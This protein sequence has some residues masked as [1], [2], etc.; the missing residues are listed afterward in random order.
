MRGVINAFA[1]SDLEM[2]KIL[3]WEMALEDKELAMK[4]ATWRLFNIAGAV[5]TMECELYEQDS[6]PESGKIGDGIG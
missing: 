1:P 6:L 4:T 5:N 2:K 3:G